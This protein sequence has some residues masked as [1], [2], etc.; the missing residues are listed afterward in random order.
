MK[1]I[2]LREYVKAP[3][4]L[5]V[6]SIPT[7]TP[8]PTQYLIAIHASALNFFDILQ[9]SGKYQHQPPFPW[10][11]GSEFS[12]VVLT[13]PKTRPPGAAAPAFKPGDRVFG[14]AQGAF[15]THVCAEEA[16][17][18]PV[19]AGWTFK[20][21]AGLMVTAPTAY[22]A[23][24]VRAR[25]Q[26]G[27]VVLVHAAAGGVGLAAVQVAKALGCTV[28]AT[29]GSARKRDVAKRFGADET[30]DYNAD[31]WEEEVKR[32]VLKRSKKKKGVD[33]VFDPVGM[34]QRS[35][36]CTA[37]NGRIV[38]VGFAAGEIEKVGMNRVL[39]KN[40][41]LVGLHWGMYAKEEKETVETVWR[42][43]Y[44]LI[45]GGRFKGTQW[46]DKKLVGLE[47]VKEGLKML[48]SRETWGKVVVEVE[49][50]D[51][52]QSKL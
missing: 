29:A 12:G 21:A 48:G 40:V 45:E 38:V 35:L 15:A 18:R 42:G 36:K 41:S 8:S 16:S 50:E 30:V 9:I 27:E 13:P 19:P 28:I 20:D 44:E 46:T 7:P 23:L 5:V 52:R 2:Q 47:S 34:V 14:A 10:I 1:A 4:N 39:L 32:L 43:L 37:W 26:P 25:A 24:V 31:G 6:S 33:V 49:V 17:L 51:G 22:A 11:A 3:D